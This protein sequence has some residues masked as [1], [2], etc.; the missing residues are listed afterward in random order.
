ML[1]I[2]INNFTTLSVQM[3]LIICV[4]SRRNWYQNWVWGFLLP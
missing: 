3:N 2:V 1:F 4:I